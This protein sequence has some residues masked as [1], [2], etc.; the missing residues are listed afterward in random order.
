MPA[1]AAD[2]RPAVPHLAA[3]EQ[4]AADRGRSLPRRHADHARRRRVHHQRRRARRGQ[5]VAPQ[6]WHRLRLARWKPASGG[7]IS[8]R[9]I[10][11]RG[12]WIELNTTKKDSVTVRIDQSGKFSAMTLLR[13]MD[14]KY[15]LDADM[16]R[17][18]YDTDEARRSSTAA[19]SARSKARSRS[20]TSSI[21][22]AASGPARSS[23][24]AARRSPRTS[25]R[26]ICTSGLKPVE[27]MDDAED[28]ADPQQP[29]RRQ[30]VQP[31]RG[32]AAD[33][34]AAASGQSA[35][36]GKGPGAVPRKVLRHE[37][38]PPGPRRPLPHQPQAEARTCRKTK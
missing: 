38:L 22:P 3:A 34:P 26:S 27:V 15:G 18:F 36:A 37:P 35:A 6:P 11:E 9:V 24:R 13:A 32:A 21:R 12:S 31:R 14:P 4:R 2:L 10:P 30:H 20:T 28:A 5:P 8:C 17:A 29:G 25:P 33:L 7:C 16:L 19:A 1:A 23:S